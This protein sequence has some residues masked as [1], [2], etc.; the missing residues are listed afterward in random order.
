MRLSV[1]SDEKKK[2][3]KT[4]RKETIE[5]RRERKETLRGEKIAFAA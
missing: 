5:R 3:Q 1:G 4:E 2:G